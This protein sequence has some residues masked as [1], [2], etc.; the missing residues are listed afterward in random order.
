MKWN[1]ISIFLF[2]KSIRTW[3]GNGHENTQCDEKDRRTK[4]F[5]FFSQKN[6][7]KENYEKKP[8]KHLSLFFHIKT[9]P[10][11]RI[12]KPC[13][14]YKRKK[15]LALCTLFKKKKLFLPIYKICKNFIFF[16]FPLHLKNKKIF[17]FKF[18]FFQN[19][20]F[21]TTVAPQKIPW[22]SFSTQTNNYFSFSFEIRLII[23]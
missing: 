16:L 12:K 4:F 5:P 6:R 9:H 17:G 22:T 18:F 15:K 13:L 2:R 1:L 3:L 19:Q 7:E 14:L 10:W 11:Q 20:L 21:L 8:T 23:E